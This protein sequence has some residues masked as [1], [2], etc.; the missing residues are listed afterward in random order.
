MALRF[1]V[2][3]TFNDETA[4]DRWKPYTADTFSATTQDTQL[5]AK[6]EGFIQSINAKLRRLWLTLQ[7]VCDLLNEAEQSQKRLP[8][9]ML[10]DV[11][12]LIV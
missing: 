11:M 12:A 5:L 6:A 1:G 2:P 10:V 3:L 4:S 9:G 7:V 8:V